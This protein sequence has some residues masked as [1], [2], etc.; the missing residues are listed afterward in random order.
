MTS[1]RPNPNRETRAFGTLE[2]RTK[3]NGSAPV[4]TGHAAVFGELSQELSGF[5][6]D[7]YVVF[8]EVVEPGAFD[9]A[10]A[11]KDDVRAF[12]EHDTSKVLGRTAA[13]T[14]RLAQDTRG[15]FVE[16]DPPQTSVGQDIIVSIDRGDIDSMSFGFRTIEDWWEPQKDGSQ[17]RHLASVELFDVS[18]VAFPAYPDTDVALRSLEHW[19]N[20]KW[21]PNEKTR[22][23][24]AQWQ[25]REQRLLRTNSV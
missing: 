15:L 8:K 20:R 5:Y 23:R 6:E 2:L 17:V 16:I 22:K 3:A 21:E 12:V 14:L 7:Q 11:G 9:R 24:R 1:R 25:Q 13:G 18:A 10:I 19:R 4:I